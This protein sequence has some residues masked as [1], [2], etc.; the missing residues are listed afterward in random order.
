MKEIVFW[1]VTSSL[2]EISGFVET[3]YQPYSEQKTKAIGFFE[4]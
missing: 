4:I 2:L 3:P 1:D